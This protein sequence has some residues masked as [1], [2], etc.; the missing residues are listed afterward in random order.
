V[1]GDDPLAG[2]DINGDGHLNDS[3]TR[4]NAWCCRF[5]TCIV[6]DPWAS[7]AVE[8]LA[9]TGRPIGGL[10]ILRLRDKFLEEVEPQI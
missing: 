3:R 1:A 6:H 8:C 2:V 9:R 5:F 7:G 4:S 10:A